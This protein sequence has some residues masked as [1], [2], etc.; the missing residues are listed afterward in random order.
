MMSLFF[1]AAGSILLASVALGCGGS[2]G[3][4]DPNLDSNHEALGS[5]S[6]EGEGT[7]GGF[8]SGGGGS[9]KQDCKDHYDGLKRLSKDQFKQE[10]K[11]CAEAFAENPEALT[12]CIDNATDTMNAQ[13]EDLVRWEQDCIEAC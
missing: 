3:R 4:S 1:R 13:I 10:T 12:R 11:W 9:C 8:G 2:D 5:G 6:G 7:G